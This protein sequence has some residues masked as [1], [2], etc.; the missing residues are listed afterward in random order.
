M[1]FAVA[2]VG[3][4]T[5]CRR[6]IDRGDANT[7]DE[8][9]VPTFTVTTPDVSSSRCKTLLTRLSGD[10]VRFT[11]TTMTPAYI[12][13]TT[14]IVG[15]LTAD[16]SGQLTGHFGMESNPAQTMP[17]AGTIDQHGQ[18]VLWFPDNPYFSQRC[19]EGTVDLEDLSAWRCAGSGQIPLLMWPLFPRAIFSSEK[20]DQIGVYSVEWSISLEPLSPAAELATQIEGSKDS[21]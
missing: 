12:D 9:V 5:L 8:D 18:W 20:V 6:A 3:G 13:G 14:G 4:V 11:G 7:V 10:G 19:L 2:F 15:H 1:G 17:M 16:A 21:R